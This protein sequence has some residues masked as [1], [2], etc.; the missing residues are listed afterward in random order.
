M[1]PIIIHPGFH[2]TGTTSLQTHLAQNA[3]TLAPWLRIYG[4]EALGDA[5]SAARRY[6]QRPFPWRLRDFRMKFRR[7]LDGLPDIPEKGGPIPLITRETLSGPMPGHRDALGRVITGYRRAALPLARTMVS[8]LRRR[9]GPDARILFF[10]TTRNREAWLKSVH[11]HL[12]RSIRLRD[13]LESFRRRLGPGPAL[14]EEV[15]HLARALAGPGVTV[16]AEPL[17]RWGSTRGGLATPLLRLAGVPD[18]VID[19]LPPAGHENRGQGDALREEFLALNRATGDKTA[20]RAA[21][22]ALLRA[23]Q[24]KRR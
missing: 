4:K 11:G 22:A 3:R 15:A 18:E 12:L 20:L 8:E 9:F 13:D 5:G 19:S 10:Y 16:H 1:G 7:F 6:G 21:K 14:E 24:E 2:K 23:E 17:E